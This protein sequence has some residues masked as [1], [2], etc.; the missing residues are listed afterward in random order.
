MPVP[1]GTAALP[2]P[3]RWCTCCLFFYLFVSTC[4]ST[5]IQKDY[6][7]RIRGILLSAVDFFWPSTY[8]VFL[9]F[10]RLGI[11]AFPKKT[12]KRA[13][14]RCPDTTRTTAATGPQAHA[15]RARLC[16][17]MAAVIPREVEEI[18]NL[19]GGVR[20]RHAVEDHSL[21]LWVESRSTALN[22][23][24]AKRGWSM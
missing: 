4:Q 12:K 10:F 2:H 9:F 20:R 13:I 16:C 5:K 21:V 24:R 22:T 8:F 18:T 17:L 19:S 23:R 14:P 15:W 11:P 3:K 7:L 1:A 6:L